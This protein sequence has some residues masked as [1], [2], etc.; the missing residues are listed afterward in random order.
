MRL[1][2]AALA[3]ALTVPLLVYASIGSFA[4]YIADDYCWAGVLREQGFLNAQVWWYV[5]YSPRYAFTFIV[6][7]VEL[8]GPG[9]VPIL[10]MVALIA[11]VAAL[12]WTIRQL[13]VR[14][15][16]LSEW[17]SAVLL[18]LVIA[19]GTLH[20]APDLPQSLYW[21]TGMLTYL[22]PLILATVVIGI[23]CRAARSGSIN[24][25]WLAACTVLTFVAGGLSETYLI[26]QNVAIALALLVASAGWRWRWP[27]AGVA[28]AGWTAA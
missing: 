11:W 26:P 1:A 18:A 20:T 25:G 8:A 28:A 19:L 9:I 2:I 16:E 23:I 3:A 17:T 15:G 24:P 7:L 14:L 13:G 12:S 6:N 10:P 21:Q 4:R 22:L 5:A 27:G